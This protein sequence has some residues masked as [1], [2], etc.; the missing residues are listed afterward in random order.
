M[1]RVRLSAATSYGYAI[2][3]EE[4]LADSSKTGRGDQPDAHLGDDILIV[5]R[6][7]AWRDKPCGA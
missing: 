7:D 3:D 1:S 2:R 4:S 5:A 6:G